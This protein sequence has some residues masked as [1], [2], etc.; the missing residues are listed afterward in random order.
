MKKRI[1]RSVALLVLFCLVAQSVFAMPVAANDSVPIEYEESGL[2]VSEQHE[3]ESTEAHEQESME[4]QEPERAEDEMDP[5]EPALSILEQ[6][7]TIEAEQSISE[8]IDHQA[9]YFGAM[10]APANRGRE[11]INLADTNWIKKIS[12][13]K[14]NPTTGRWEEATTF[15]NGD[16]VRIQMGYSIPQNGLANYNTELIYQLPD[17]VVLESAQQGPVYGPD[18]SIIESYQISTDGRVSILFNEHFD[19]A[20]VQIGTI[21]ISGSLSNDST[22]EDK[23]IRFPGTGIS[24]TV[25]K[26]EEII[27]PPEDDSDLSVQKSAELQSDKKQIRYTVTA[28]SVNGTSGTVRLIDAFTWGQNTNA[29]YAENSFSIVKVGQNGATTPININ[30]YKPQISTTASGQPTFTISELPPLGGGESYRLQYTA[31]LTNMENTDGTQQIN[32]SIKA[33]SGA[34]TDNASVSMQVSKSMINKSGYVSNGYIHWTITVNADGRDLK[35]YVLADQLPSGTMLTGEVVVKNQRT[36]GTVSGL[37]QAREGDSTLRINFANLDASQSRDSFIVT[38]TTNAPAAVAG[39]SIKIE[40]TG[41][42]TNTNSGEHYQSTGTVYVS[43]GRL[44]VNKRFDKGVELAGGMSKYTWWSTL[45]L[46]GSETSGFEYTDTIQNA[47]SE[48]ENGIKTDEGIESHYTTAA[49]LNSDLSSYKTRILRKSG[50]NGAYL[51]YEAGKDYLYTI[52]CYDADG[53]IIPN[54]NTVQIVKSFTIK[55]VPAPGKTISP[56]SFSIQYTT[57]AD[58]GSGAGG[59]TWLYSNTGA[60]T[61]SD[62]KKIYDVSHS[63]NTTHETKK[64]IAKQASLTGNAGSYGTADIS[65]DITDTQGI[66]FY[67]ILVN[68]DKGMSGEIVVEDILSQGMEYVAESFEAA[69]YVND[70]YAQ[71]TNYNNYDLAGEQKPTLELSENADGT[72]RLTITI[73]EGYERAAKDQTIQLTYRAAFQDDSRWLDM[74]N[75]TLTYSNTAKWNGD[76]DTHITEVHREVKAVEKKARQLTD[77]EGNLTNTVQYIVNINPGGLDLNPNGN[78]L[79]L[80][81]TLRIPEGTSAYLDLSNTGLYKYDSSAEDNVGVRLDP[82]LYKLSYDDST[83]LITVE[84]MDAQA[85][86]LVYQYNIDSADY[87]SPS[88]SNDVE[89]AGYY[90]DSNSMNLMNNESSATV[91]GKQLVLYKIDADDYTRFLQGA[92]FAIEKRANGSW[93]L[94]DPSTVSASGVLVTDAQGRLTLTNL[95]DNTLYRI[96]ETSAPTGYR[97]SSKPNYVIWSNGDIS[98]ED[99]Y[100]GLDEEVKATVSRTDIHFVS[101]VGGVLYVPNE[102]T[103]LEVKKVWLNLDGTTGAPGAPNVTV[104]L[105][106]A[107][108]TLNA[109]DVH[110]LIK[111]SYTSTSMNLTVDKG[112]SVQGVL[113]LIPEQQ[114]CSG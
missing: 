6:T 82:S 98:N 107:K 70:W 64:A 38:Y 66:L 16:T 77:S 84:V 49:V 62:G 1:R 14:L 29:S 97:Q 24:I 54:N 32:N 2:S 111:N 27:V 9:N 22:Q 60:I 104:H 18:G 21:N 88:I 12:V 67:K 113:E 86:V 28:S 114:H 102:F 61:E 19:P 20:I 37:T 36:Q 58:T 55:V 39:D 93:V 15:L 42:L 17:G 96:T 44:S 33:E 63:A 23:E 65:T 83:H 51:D 7:E 79:T 87:Q 43:E 99:L 48:D 85:C 3:A 53:N 73:P 103:Q 8:A 45:N 10:S 109:V 40:N 105:Y 75:L 92:H 74:S 69:F 108:K 11:S 41:H 35:D 101:Y 46:T 100:A 13:G 56:T 59:E 78:T 112:S 50:N 57:I 4:G 91:Y 89:L 26:S 76:S 71:S 95:E 80:Y 106:R 30:T 5:E 52:T 110:V 68:I 31:N 25:K 90:S 81:D 94:V 47:I 34:K 72:T